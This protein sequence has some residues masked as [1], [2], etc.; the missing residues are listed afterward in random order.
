MAAS[1]ATFSARATFP[2]P[3]FWPTSVEVAM[4]NPIA[5][6]SMTLNTFTPTPKLAVTTV[7]KL[8]MRKVSTA[9]PNPRADCSMEA[10]Y[11]RRNAR[12]TKFRSG[13]KSCQ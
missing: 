13:M 6:I 2:A 5:G 12:F 4:E 9:I 11:P 1:F 10:G 7:P 8:V 3:M